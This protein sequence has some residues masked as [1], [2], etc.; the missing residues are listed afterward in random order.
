MD[1]QT[2][3]YTANPSA[4]QIHDAP[5]RIK[6]VCGPVGS[7]KSTVA[8]W[9]FW[10]LCYESPIPLH[11]VV[12]RSSYRE[13]HDSTRKTFDYWFAAISTYKEG[14]EEAHLTF[15]GRDGVSRT[16]TLA[17]RACKRE[18][19]AQKFMSTEYAF[20]WLEEVVPAFTSA[21]AAGGVMGAGLPRG[22][23]ALA[24][25]RLRQAGA[26]R[27]E[28]LLTFNPPATTHWT[29]AEFFQTPGEALERKNIA[30]F[31]QPPGENATNLRASYY[32]ELVE[33]LSPDLAR[34]F[35][36]G[37]VTTTYEGERVFPECIENLHIVDKLDPVPGVPLTLGDDYG[38]TPCAAVT[39]ILPGGQ[40][41]IL[42]ELQ[43]VNRGIKAFIEYLGPY[44][45]Q[46][47]PGFSVRKVWQDPA[48]GNQRSQIDETET[49]GALLRQAGYEVADGRNEWALRREIM[50][51]RFEWSPGGKPGVLVSRQ[52]CPIIT[53]GLL[54]GYRYPTTA[55]GVTGTS[56]IKNAFSHLADSLQMIA[57][58]EFSLLSGLVSKD[59]LAVR[60]LIRRHLPSPF[61][62][63]P[64]AQRHSPR[65]W[66]RR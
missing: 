43:L 31:R 36:F 62:P 57:T 18:A 27:V 13:L 32:E 55:A 63:N 8:C 44:L 48:G 56:P 45:Q 50:K 47:F 64:P 2:I 35:V 4:V 14:D 39:Q 52:D 51:Q 19:E 38:L 21:R 49:C 28:I 22:V 16:H 40:W 9:E 53:E 66:M 54:G 6:A 20:I 41:L 46:N 34:R 15:A 17:F 12:I 3:N 61:T 26:P 29:Y 37:E 59:E 30:F 10:L 11:G 1:P 23:Y 5:H 42:G 65:G 24:Q 60:E 7:G 58:G 33:N 25:M